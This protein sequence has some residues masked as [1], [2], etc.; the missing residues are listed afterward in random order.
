MSNQFKF[1][2][3]FFPCLPN[4]QAGEV[5]HVRI[6]FS[7]GN[8]V[9][10][11]QSPATEYIDWKRKSW[12]V[13]ASTNA[14]IM[15]RALCAELRSYPWFCTL[16]ATSRRNA[17]AA[18]ALAVKLSYLN[19]F[20]SDAQYHEFHLNIGKT[21]FNERGVARV[22]SSCN[23]W[24]LQEDGNTFDKWVDVSTTV[25]EAFAS[26]AELLASDR[27]ASAALQRAIASSRSL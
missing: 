2:D 16:S 8:W 6:Y 11:L 25:V 1:L 14:F 21:I 17:K 19:N 4:R 26:T 3:R 27:T 9:V 15:H 5:V 20:R 10:G 24:W 22:D 7:V 23:L 13:N 12:Y 18:V